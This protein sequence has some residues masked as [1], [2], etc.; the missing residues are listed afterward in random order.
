MKKCIVVGASGYSGSQLTDLI[1]KHPELQLAGLAV[2]PESKAKGLL[3][4]DL[5]PEYSGSEAASQYRFQPWLE[6][7]NTPVDI[8]FLAT[9]HAL[10]AQLAVELIQQQKQVIDLSGAFRLRQSDTA[11]QFYN[12]DK[13]AC[14]LLESAVYGLPELTGSGLYDASLIAVAGC[15]PSV[16]ILSLAPLVAAGFNLGTPVIN[17]V[18]G[19]SG[20]GRSANLATS[21]CEVSLRAYG[22]GEHRHLPEIEQALGTKAVFTPHLGNFKRGIFATITVQLDSSQHASFSQS[23]LQ[24][25]YDEYYQNAEFIRVV[26]DIPSVHHVEKTPNLHLAVRYLPRTHSIQLFA[27][28]DNLMKGAASAA[29][30]CCNLSQG[31]PESFGLKTFNSKE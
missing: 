26:E 18:S 30:Q 31:W 17:A 16:S 19:V 15:Y 24:A 2:S 8:V 4:T 25:L 6:L 10:S 11:V 1:L 13:N 7:A 21:F 28:I 23:E 22:I 5:F 27:V 9:P 14:Q 12:L 3:F 29:I 20:A